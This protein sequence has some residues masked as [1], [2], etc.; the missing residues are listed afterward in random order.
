MFPLKADGGLAR[1]RRWD[2]GP[3]RRCRRC[4]GSSPRDRGREESKPRW[5]GGHV[6]RNR[7]DG[8]RL[9]DV[10][11]RC[12]GWRPGARP[13][14]DRRILARGRVGARIRRVCER[15][16]GGPD[17][18]RLGGSRRHDSALDRLA[19]E[20]RF[21]GRHDHGRVARAKTDGGSHW[22]SVRSSDRR[23]TRDSRGCGGPRDGRIPGRPRAARHIHRSGSRCDARP[24]E[25]RKRRGRIPFGTRRGRLRQQV[26]R[27]FLRAP[28][29]QPAGRAS[30]GP[31]GSPTSR[32]ATR[33]RTRPRSAS[34]V[35]ELCCCATREFA[36]HSRSPRL[37][38]TVR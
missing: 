11:P 34:P 27:W 38:L 6:G 3:G 20:D 24:L 15:A 36:R 32:L 33:S 26:P 1:D 31:V 14:F 28:C 35:P 5:V 19:A 23:P 25:H 30:R 9:R 17:G 4:R 16:L 8:S 37:T 22:K 18:I 12:A 7:L 10:A 2:G 13:G 21:G 29:A